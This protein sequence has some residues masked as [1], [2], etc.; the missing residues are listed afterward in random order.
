MRVKIYGAGSIGNHL[1]QA[2][3]RMG[4]E[5][6]V[7]DTDPNALKRMKEEI[8]PTRYGAWDDGITLYESGTEPR[9]GYEL[10][11]I[12]TPPHVR[13]K[14]ALAALEERPKILLLEKPLSFP[15]DPDLRV[16]N[17]KA[18]ATPETTILVG[19]DHAV[20]SAIERISLLLREQSIGRV[21]TI[22]VEFREHWQGIF[23][24]HPWLS[25]PADSYLGFWQRGGGASGE[26]SHALHL[27]QHLAREAGWG[28]WHKVSALFKIEREQGAE[29]DSLA[30][31]LFQ[32]TDGNVG[33]VVQDV[34]TLPVRK[35]ARI[36]GTSGFIEWICNGVPEGDLVRI[37]KEGGEVAEEVFSKK[38]PDDFYREMQHID[39]LM[40][41]SVSGDTSPLRFDTGLAVMQVLETSWENKGEI[42]AIIAEK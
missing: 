39:G 25:G 24:A 32:T 15:F 36:Q 14:L 13:T 38:R 20:S 42:A 9:E 21:Q 19:Y 33:R 26:H 34:I 5:V 35:W 41:G 6:A 12:G 17:E 7:V 37:A 1:A 30:T 31:F 40:S 16:L 10:I 27:W 11:C 3:R 22:D 28:P 4:W 23:K 29:Y 2:A 8:Y 18:A